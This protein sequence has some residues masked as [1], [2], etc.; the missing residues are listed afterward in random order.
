MFLHPQPP[1]PTPLMAQITSADSSRP[2][3]PI[4]S[5]PFCVVSSTPTG[6]NPSPIAPL[7]DPGLCMM[8]NQGCGNRVE[9][10]KSRKREREEDPSLSSWIKKKISS[11]G[12]QLT[13]NGWSDD[14]NNRFCMACSSLGDDISVTMRREQQELDLFILMQMEKLRVE[15]E[16]KR[17]SYWFNL[18]QT[19]EQGMQ[20]VLRDKDE[21]IA[22]ISRKNT[23]LEE[24]VKILLMEGQIWKTVAQTNEATATSLRRDLELAHEKGE[25]NN[26]EVADSESCCD[27]GMVDGSRNCHGCH[28]KEISVL[29]LPCRHLCLCNDCDQRFGSCPLC[30]CT[31]SA[32][33][34]VHMS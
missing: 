20:R 25:G 33:I 29:V 17:R 27:G 14:C 3:N 16:Q 12:G 15:L 2:L 26:R 19:L 23:A 21:Q 5:F 30:M 24:K 10:S 18:F 1:S 31:K 34:K 9:F 11:S 7:H 4:S 22:A 32:S 8:N 6:H 13:A 28:E